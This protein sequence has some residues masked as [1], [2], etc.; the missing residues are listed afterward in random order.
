MKT[1]ILMLVAHE[2]DLF[3]ASLRFMPYAEGDWLSDCNLYHIAG[4]VPVPRGYEDARI[5]T[6]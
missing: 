4:E 5:K 1:N 3:L 2:K 6:A